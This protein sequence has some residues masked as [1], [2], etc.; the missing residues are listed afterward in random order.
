MASP[1]IRDRRLGVKDGRAR[2]KCAIA[3]SIGFQIA[4]MNQAPW[5]SQTII[6]EFAEFASVKIDNS[7][8]PIGGF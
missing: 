7:R 1:G 4:K 8:E 2:Y 3:I 5:L 6:C